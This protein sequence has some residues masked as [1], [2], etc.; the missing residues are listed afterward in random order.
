[1]S[2]VLFVSSMSVSRRC[3]SERWCVLGRARA[4]RAALAASGC[5]RNS[6]SSESSLI[7][8]SRRG[9]ANAS[10][11]SVRCSE[12]LAAMGGALVSADLRTTLLEL[13]RARG[14]PLLAFRRFFW[15]TPHG[16]V[17]AA[18]AAGLR[19]PWDSHFYASFSLFWEEQKKF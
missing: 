16:V 1:M 7:G 4:A 3:S 14:N 2:W 13:A 18:S 11:R 17:V 15:D 8:A 9:R 19:G 5:C 6:L 10:E 12:A